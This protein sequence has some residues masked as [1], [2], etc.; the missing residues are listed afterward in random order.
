MEKYAYQTNDTDSNKYDIFE[1]GGEVVAKSVPWD[2]VEKLIGFLNT[3]LNSQFTALGNV[4][5]IRNK[6]R[7]V[8]ALK[9]H[10]CC[11]CSKE[12]EKGSEYKNYDFMPE[13]K[14]YKNLKAHDAC[15]MLIKGFHWNKRDLSIIL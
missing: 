6:T 11:A 4:L 1:I 7:M 5:P 9:P 13:N 2:L 12:I 8:R 3:P 14:I 15:G 10:I